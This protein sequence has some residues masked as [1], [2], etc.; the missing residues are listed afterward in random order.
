ME[1]PQIFYD[2]LRQATLN[3]LFFFTHPERVEPR[4]EIVA[5]HAAARLLFPFHH[6]FAD[7]FFVWEWTHTRNFDHI[8]RSKDYSGYN[9]FGWVRSRP[10]LHRRLKAWS[11]GHWFRHR[12]YLDWLLIFQPK[13]RYVRQLPGH[14]RN[15]IEQCWR[16][17]R[18][19]CLGYLSFQSSSSLSCISQTNFIRNEIKIQSFEYDDIAI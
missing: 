6:A 8:I 2:K 11:R 16:R 7:F 18:S 17:T 5:A 19:P 13:G 1:N 10:R 12:L 15:P 4:I 3:I 9:P 14:L